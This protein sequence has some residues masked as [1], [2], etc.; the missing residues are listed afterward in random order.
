MLDSARLVQTEDPWEPIRLLDC[1][2]ER[3]EAV[4]L[5]LKDLLAA[6]S[7]VTTL[8]SYGM[9]L[10]RWWR[11]L[12]AVNTCWDRAVREDARDFMLW[13]Q[14]VDKP[15]RVHWRHRDQSPEAPELSSSRKPGRPAPGTPNLVT[16]KPTVGTK[17]AASTRAHCETVLRA[18]YDFHLERNS[19]SLLVNPFPLGHRLRQ[20]RP[21]AHRNP[22]DGFRPERTG[23]YRPKVPERIPRRITDDKFS[24]VF[25][26]LRSHRDRALLAFWVSTGARASELLTSNQRDAVVG[27]QVIG[28]I[29]KGTRAYQQLPAS[30][31]AFVWLRLYQEE[32]W[33]AGV[34][35]G[36]DHALWWTLRRPWRPLEYHAARAMFVRANDVLGANWT[37]HDLRH[38]ATYRMTR[39]PGMSLVYVQHILGHKYQSTLQKYINPSKDEVIEAGLAHHARQEHKRNNPPP[40]PPSPAYNPDSLNVLFGVRP[41]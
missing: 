33:L 20:G 39:D 2:G 10:L 17:Y 9:D 30:P 14:V 27:Q 12:A 28:V 15:V 23:R 16:G 37:L 3:I 1:S 11:F 34:P 26:S 19:G 24:E 4:A 41:S 21:N 22:M 5:Y 7:P 8:R 35:R 29:R 36:R 31:D 18:F 40:A 38:T 25:A 32:S 13:M 6:G